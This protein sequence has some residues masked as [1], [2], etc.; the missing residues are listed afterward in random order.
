MS[1]RASDDFRL[2][3]S[4]YDPP[5]PDESEEEDDGPDP[6]DLRDQAIERQERED[7]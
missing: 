7:E 1:W 4:Y 5:D 6:D 2:P 3:A